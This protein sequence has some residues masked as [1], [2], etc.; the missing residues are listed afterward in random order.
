MKK[1]NPNPVLLL[2]PLHDLECKPLKGSACSC[3]QLDWAQCG[4][5]ADTS[6]SQGDCA[7]CCWADSSHYSKNECTRKVFLKWA[8]QCRQGNAVQWK[9]HLYR[10]RS[11]KRA[12]NLRS[13]GIFCHNS[14]SWLCDP[15]EDPEP[16]PAFAVGSSSPYIIRLVGLN[17]PL[18]V[19]C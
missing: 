6:Q 16:L 4:Y 18:Y 10:M 9:T 7:E 12:W 5:K 8:G 2:S 11:L 3:L 1:T 14:T 17:E 15:R 13:G 19:T